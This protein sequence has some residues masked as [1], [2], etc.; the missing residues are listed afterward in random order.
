MSVRL[1]I[2]NL[3]EP[4]LARFAQEVAFMLGA[5]DT[6]ALEGDLGAGKTTFARALIRALTGDPALEVPSPTFTLAQSY[7]TPRFEVAHFDLYRLTT[8]D[9]LE[10]LGLDAALQRG[11][12]I[13]EWPSRAHGRL[14]DER[15]TLTL[16]EGESADTRSVILT[17]AP[18]L[19]PRLAR[20]G[21]IRTFLDAAGWG[22]SDTALSYLQ[23]DASA[24]RYARLK[25]AGGARAILMD[26]PRQP[27]G[28]PIRDGLP[29]SRIAHLAEDVRPFVAIGNALSAA[30][31][32]TPEIMAHD[33]DHG[34]LL[35]EDFGDAVFGS[36]VANGVDQAQL[37][38]RGT[39]TLVALRAVRPAPSLPLP[40]G[41]SYSV[42]P[43][44]LG[45]ILIETELLTD[46]YWPAVYGTPI[47]DS[48]RR[49]FIAAWT[50]VARRVLAAP[51]GWMLRDYHSPNLIA[52]DGR[53]PPRDVGIIDFQDALIGPD[54]FDLVS[55]LQDARLDV[56][57]TLEHALLDRYVARVHS[58]EPHFDEVQFRFTYAALG[59]QRNTKILGI[60]ARLA[61]RDGKRQY[62][63]HIPR[64]WGYLARSLTH[65]GL[66]TL[67]AWYDHDL[68]PEV[69]RRTLNV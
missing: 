3:S 65:P 30:G 60:F 12:A 68:P 32:S 14:P 13:V 22:K 25:R 67:A 31:F 17:S 41:T 2:P 47:P 27:D 39:D 62:L 19:E 54:A 57:K 9:D 52:L 51:R 48:V 20:L 29:Y 8:P 50:E 7:A 53:R 61:K 55:L 42:P 10:E 46:W 33:L 58:L 5:G 36:E 16:S 56:S 40:D 21:D 35:I 43:L 15:L 4:D 69:R 45:V 1:T 49:D 59:V 23:G 63:A 64:I 44:D 26:A 6:L 24:R 34:L 66:A 37:W 11:I 38:Q 18:S 28:P